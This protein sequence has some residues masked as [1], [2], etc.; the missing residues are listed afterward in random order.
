M[1]ERMMGAMDKNT[2]YTHLKVSKNKGVNK[3]QDQKTKHTKVSA[4]F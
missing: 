1:D 3:K 2:L 4:A